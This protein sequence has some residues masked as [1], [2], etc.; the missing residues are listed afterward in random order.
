MM[1]CYKAELVHTFHS[2]SEDRDY[3]WYKYTNRL[4]PVNQFGRL[5]V[6]KEAD[7]T[8]LNIV[9]AWIDETDEEL[10]QCLFL[11]C[12]EM[13]SAVSW[14]SETDENGNTTG[15]L[16]GGGQSINGGRNYGGPRHN[17]D[18]ASNYEVDE[19]DYDNGALAQTPVGKAIAKGEKEKNLS[20][21]R[22]SRHGK[23]T[24]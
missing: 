19:T 8:E 14:T 5:V 22:K 3:H 17:A 10:G 15:N 7:D 4:M 6:D 23:T 2:E 21:S 1:W 24:R 12:G 11:E 20:R 18:S 16:S 13:G 9:P